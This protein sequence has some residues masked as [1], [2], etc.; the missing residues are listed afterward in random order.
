MP[1]VRIKMAV[2]MA[3]TLAEEAHDEVSL[4]SRSSKGVFFSPR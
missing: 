2:I 4:F 1:P 3:G